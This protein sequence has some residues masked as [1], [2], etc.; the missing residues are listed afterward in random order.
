MLHKSNLWSEYLS[1]H[2]PLASS[3]SRCDGS[4]L[5]AYASESGSGYGE[6]HTNDLKAFIKYQHLKR[7]WPD[8]REYL[9]PSFVK[10]ID[11]LIDIVEAQSI[12][13]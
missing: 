1:G 11:G 7:R 12:S 13:S 6:S 2:I 9:E 8:L 10:Y 4:M 5:P 3:E